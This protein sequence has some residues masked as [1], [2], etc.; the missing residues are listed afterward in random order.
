VLELF[1]WR[2]DAAATAMLAAPTGRAA[3]AAELADVL[4]WVLL[5]A[6]DQGIDLAEALRGKLVENARKYPV[7]RAR[8][9]ADKYTDLA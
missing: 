5:M 4:S 3:L 7:E 9:R 1:Q 8:G 2:T 6:H